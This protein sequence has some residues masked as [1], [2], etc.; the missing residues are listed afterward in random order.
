MWRNK[1][2][3]NFRHIFTLLWCTYLVYIWWGQASKI[4]MLRWQLDIRVMIHCHISSTT[5]QGRLRE[6]GTRGPSTTPYFWNIE[7]RTEI[8]RQTNSRGFPRFFNL[9]PLHEKRGLSIIKPALQCWWWRYKKSPNLLH[10]RIVKCLL[11]YLSKTVPSIGLSKSCINEAIFESSW[12]WQTIQKSWFIC[13]C[14]FSSKSLLY[15]NLH[16][17][18]K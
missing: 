12:Q 5:W 4:G 14:Y 15:C 1:P 16:R 13:V 8:G 18:N 17:N 2:I 3:C 6:G 9:P 11:A 10:C 7:K